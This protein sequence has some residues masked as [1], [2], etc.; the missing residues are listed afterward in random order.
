MLS[1]DSVPYENTKHSLG[2][3]TFII[4]QCDY[5]ENMHSYLEIH[6]ERTQTS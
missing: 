3:N 5:N 1:D 4:D 6:K 2:E